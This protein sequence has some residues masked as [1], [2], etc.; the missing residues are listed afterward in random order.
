VADGYLS[1]PFCGFEFVR[2]DTLCAH[3][4]PMGAVCG[5]IHCP[6]C[7]YE[8]PENPQR[9]TWLEWLF[10]R[11]RSERPELPEQVRT[12]IELRPGQRAI[13]LC[14]GAGSPTRHN[15]LAVFGLVPGAELVLVQQSPSCVVRVGETELALDPDIA[16]QILVHGADDEALV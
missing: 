1:C 4:C 6:S 5:L 3:G 8:F 2:V 13:V 15:S 14:L 12:V 10:P 16:R 11:R 9:V 7:G